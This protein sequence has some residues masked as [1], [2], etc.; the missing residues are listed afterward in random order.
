MQK[1]LIY[2]K[3]PYQEKGLIK[4]T[5]DF[6]LRVLTLGVWA[7]LAFILGS[8]LIDALLHSYN[9]MIKVWWFSYCFTIFLGA[10]WLAYIVLFVRDYYEAEE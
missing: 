3:K 4:A 9:P 2:F 7:Y 6:L 10:T 5:L 8:L 1:M